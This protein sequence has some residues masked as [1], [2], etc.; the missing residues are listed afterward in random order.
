MEVVPRGAGRLLGRLVLQE[1]RRP[2]EKD[3][4]AAGKALQEVLV[5][6][7]PVF[8]GGPPSQSCQGESVM[9][10]RKIAICAVS[11][12]VAF[13]ASIVYRRLR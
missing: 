1:A 2:K 6:R 8:A 10:T 7:W 3:P 5:P 4:E 11:F 12:V 13:V 9:D